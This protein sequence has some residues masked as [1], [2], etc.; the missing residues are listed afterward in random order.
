[1]SEWKRSTREVT[2][3]QLPADMQAEIQKHIEVYNLGDVLSDAVMCVQTDSEKTKKVI[4]G[5]AETVQMGAVVTPRWLVW[6]AKGTKTS[7]AVLSAFLPD[8]VIQ[9]YADTQFAKLV[10]D[11]GLEVSGKFTAAAESAS[12]FIGLENNSAGQKF[13]D[14]VLRA[15]EDAKK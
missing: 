13:K 14:T 4:F 15:V 3:A 7:S 9:N 1:M 12:A 5:S 8:V 11:S 10:P 2:F 6:V